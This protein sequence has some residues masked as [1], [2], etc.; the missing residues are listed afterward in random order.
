[1]NAIANV[2]KN[3]PNMDVNERRLRAFV[4]ARAAAYATVIDPQADFK[5][6]LETEVGR[7]KD[8][9]QDINEYILFDINLACDLF[10]SIYTVRYEVATDCCDETICAFVMQSTK[11]TEFLNKENN[12]MVSLI[13][14]DER[15]KT[16]VSEVANAFRSNVEGQ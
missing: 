2:L 13:L 7:F 14:K 10:K 8:I 9:L 12:N 1:M 3:I 16:A 6:T 4:V 15:I 5:E 11:Q